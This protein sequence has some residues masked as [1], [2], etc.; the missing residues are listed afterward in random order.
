[1]RTSIPGQKSISVSSTMGPFAESGLPAEPV[2]KSAE[3][4]LETADPLL[5]IFMLRITTLRRFA[6]VVSTMT[7]GAGR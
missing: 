7:I 5:D 3:P 1:M 4:V 6:E 2:L